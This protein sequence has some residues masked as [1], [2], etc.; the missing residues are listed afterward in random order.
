MAVK[1]TILVLSGLLLSLTVIEAGLRLTGSIYISMKENRNQRSIKEKGEYR[2]LCLGES[3]TDRQWP[4]PLEN[5]LDE[6]CPGMKISV[7]DCGVAGT[8]TGVILSMLDEYIKKYRPDMIIAMMGVNDDPSAVALP[9]TPMNP[10]TDIR[11][12]VKSFRVYKLLKIIR[13]SIS[14]K[15]KSIS[16]FLEEG[17]LSD[18]TANEKKA[19]TGSKADEKDGSIT[20]VKEEPVDKDPEMKREN[21]QKYIELARC[22]RDRGKYGPAEVM[23]KKALQINPGNHAGNIEL[24]NQYSQQGKYESAEVYYKKALQMNPGDDVI[25]IA[26]T[27]LYSQ[28]GNLVQAEKYYERALEMRPGNEQG[29]IELARICREQGK[30]GKAEVILKKNLAI[31]PVNE[32]GY[33]ELGNLYRDQGK[34]GK[35]EATYK[36]AIEIKP[37]NVQ[38][39]IDLGNLYLEIKKYD[40]AEE[41]FKKAIEVDPEYFYGYVE[42]G[43]L[44][45][46]QEKYGKAEEMLKKS[47]E[48]NPGNTHANNLKIELEQLKM[49]FDGPTERVFSYYLPVTVENYR[50]LRDIADDEKIQLVCVQYP[51]RRLEPLKQMLGTD[52]GI[53]FVDNEESFKEAVSKEGINAYFWDMFIEDFGHCTEKGNR[54]LA[55]NIAEVIERKIFNKRIFDNGQKR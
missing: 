38:G 19:K 31:N 52:S 44:Y 53:T 24:A 22:Y 4:G 13:I 41:Y 7:I 40:R 47:L 12:F 30:F 54:L 32:A 17:I 43:M 39:Y 27:K 15:I 23:Y 5:I 10:Y 48:I 51:M 37:E 28:E 6:R 2:I 46:E 29:Y 50:K 18:N 21:V 11:S 45:K 14:V 26:L 3:T 36:K 25:N 16:R 33:I 55:Q 9:V 8:N 1:R 35:A 49:H 34:N 42:L 20:N